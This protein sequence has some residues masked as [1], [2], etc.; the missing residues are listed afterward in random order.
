MFSCFSSQKWEQYDH[1]T[2]T[3]AR[4]IN[5]TYRAGELAQ[6]EKDLAAQER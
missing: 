1:N 5:V 2:G 4:T 3:T 6:W